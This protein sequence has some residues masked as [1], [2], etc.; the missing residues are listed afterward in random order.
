M[1]ISPHRTFFVRGS[2]LGFS[3]PKWF[4]YAIWRSIFCNRDRKGHICNKL[5]MLKQLK[6]LNAYLKNIIKILIFWFIEQ[7]ISQNFN[8]LSYDS[9]GSFFYSTVNGCN[10]QI[11]LLDVMQYMVYVFWLVFEIFAKI[12]FLIVW[13]KML[14]NC[15][16]KSV[17]KGLVPCSY[18]LFELPVFVVRLSWGRIGL[19]VLF[20][21]IDSLI[22][23]QRA[24][25]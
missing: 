6:L 23:T 13:R 22:P 25:E 9:R 15:Q 14:I 10:S 1:N 11:Y 4:K 8:F 12:V 18:C 16:H 21:Y 5:L 20:L 17:F 24:I 3:D 19:E 7:E 2:L